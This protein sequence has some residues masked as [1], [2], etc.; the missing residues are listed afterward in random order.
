MNNENL[1]PYR[2]ETCIAER[3]EPGMIVFNVR[4]GGVADRELAMGWLMGI[5]RNGETVFCNAYEQPP[6]DVRGLANGNFLFSQTDHGVINEMTRNGEIVRQ[7]YAKG[8]WQDASPPENAVAL[9]IDLYHHRINTFPNGNLLLLGMEIREIANWPGSETDPAAPTETARVV[10]DVVTEVALDGSVVNRWKMLDMLD[11][12]RLCYGSRSG[13][14]VRRGFPDTNDWCHANAVAYDPRDASILVSLRTQD[15]IVKFGAETGEIVWI[16]GTHANWKKPW[17]EKLLTPVGDL[18]WQF[19]QHDC[20]ITP[21]GRI[22]CFDNG[23]Y[24]ATP[25]DQK[26][27][28]EKN[29]SRVVEFDVDEKARTVREVWSYAGVPAD[30]LYACYQGGAFR[31]PQTG[32][33]LMTYGGIVTVDG[34]PHDVAEAGFCRARLV[35]VTSDGEVVFDLWIDGS[36]E[37]PPLPLSVFRAE[38]LP[39]IDAS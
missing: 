15:C 1:P 30:R 23:N 27:P 10:G 38:H 31:L 22:L 35:E 24:R 34:K 28:P 9:D 5:D 37:D 17:S 33:T 25:F 4:P 3:R 20:S 32:N 12:F 18:A 29:Y 6:Q 21:N 13:Y 2:I 14:W 39:P 7:W 16:L 19:H 8:I 36:G 26:L 11:P